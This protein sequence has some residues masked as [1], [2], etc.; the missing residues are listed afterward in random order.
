LSTQRPSQSDEVVREIER[1]GAEF[2]ALSSSQ[3]AH[4]SNGCW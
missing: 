1:V 2:E 3:L 4:I